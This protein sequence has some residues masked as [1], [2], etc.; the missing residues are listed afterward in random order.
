MT[1]CFVA[2]GDKGGGDYLTSVSAGD[3]RREVAPPEQKL[4][5]NLT[6]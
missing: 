5:C 1:L 6:C 4:G 2:V 3:G